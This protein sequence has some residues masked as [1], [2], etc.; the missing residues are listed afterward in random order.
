MHS[1]GTD[2]GAESE[3]RYGSGGGVITCLGE[4]ALL[5]RFNRFLRIRRL[6][7]LLGLL[8]RGGNRVGNRRN[9]EIACRALVAVAVNGMQGCAFVN[10]EAMGAGL[11]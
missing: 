7:G 2:G 10:L 8:L 3:D 9:R 11:G 5:V 1:G 6:R 4:V